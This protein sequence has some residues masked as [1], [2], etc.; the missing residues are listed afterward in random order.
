MEKDEIMEK[1]IK[2]LIADEEEDFCHACRDVL[3][4]TEFS[5][6]FAKKD[7]AELL[8]TIFE[9]KPDVVLGSAFLSTLDMIG[10]IEKAK[11]TLGDAIPLFMVIVPAN[12][13]ILEQELLSAGA[14]YCFIRPLN[15]SALAE[16]IH[17]F[18]INAAGSVVSAASK[19][20]SNMEVIVTDII[21]QIGVPAHI[22]G[23]HYLRE[24]I[25]MAVD[26]I[27]IMNSVTK[28]LYPSVAKKHSTT[29]SRVERAIRH[30]I[31]VAWDR[32]DVDVLNS[33]FGYTIHSG[34]GKPTNSEFIA[35]I[36]DKLRIG[37]KAG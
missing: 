30:A 15:F 4:P 33:Y 6:S 37:T 10:V 21:H 35:L 16:R 23:Y 1:K 14:A 26:D 3:S 8:S 25:M 18:Y 29:S 31:E 2:I 5:L 20:P 27:D 12:N 9:H 24:A 11:L 36:A 13:A 22:K 28:C 17:S 19:E 34:K 32:G 7:G